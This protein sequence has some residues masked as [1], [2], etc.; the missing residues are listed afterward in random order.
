MSYTL[1]Y[2]GSEIDDILDRAVAGG[3]IDTEMAGK[4]DV[5]T[6]DEVPTENSTNPVESGGVY[7]YVNALLIKESATPGSVASFPDGADGL[8]VESLTIRIVPAQSGSGDPSPTNIRTISGRTGANIYREAAYDPAA[9]PVIA[10]DWT[11]EAGT[12]YGGTLDVTTGLLTVDEALV[13][14]GNQSWNYGSGATAFYANVTD[15]PV[16][17]NGGYSNAYCSHY[18]VYTGN[19]EGFRSGDKIIT[20]FNL[21]VSNNRGRIFVRDT[22]YGND[23]NAFKASL[24]GAKLVYP[25]ETPT[26]YQLTPSQVATLLGANNIWADCGDVAELTYIADPALYI[27]NAVGNGGGLSLSMSAPAISPSITPSLQ[28]LSEPEEPTEEE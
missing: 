11:S 28:S 5:L 8:P 18:K 3:T 23:A 6:F 16:S 13:D 22:T 9:T 26:T 17:I 27:Q 7:T 10:I 20:V 19:A 25:I 12:I 1:K 15:A 21:L 24:E 2:T 4:Q 14:L